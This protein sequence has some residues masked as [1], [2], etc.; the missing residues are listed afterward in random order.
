[1]PRTSP[2]HPRVIEMTCKKEINRDITTI[3]EVLNG[4][5]V[6]EIKGILAVVEG[7]CEKSVFA[8]PEQEEIESVVIQ[9][10]GQKTI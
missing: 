4:Y 10:F 2:H 8:V 9:I 5:S 3:L 6:H 7:I 1:M